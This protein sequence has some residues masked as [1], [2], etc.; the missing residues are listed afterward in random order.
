MITETGNIEMTQH[1]QSPS[2]S[3]DELS[4]IVMLWW[5]VQNQVPVSETKML[6]DLVESFAADLIWSM[7]WWRGKFSLSLMTWWVIL[8]SMW[9]YV[10]YVWKTFYI[11]NTQKYFQLCVSELWRALF[12]FPRHWFYL[13]V[14]TS[15]FY[16]VSRGLFSLQLTLQFT[17]LQITHHSLLLCK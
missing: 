15:L 11:N 8:K 6:L 17:I 7:N 14:F 16:S 4:Y 2:S 3:V 12:E 1:H 9:I 5:N 13:N 10:N